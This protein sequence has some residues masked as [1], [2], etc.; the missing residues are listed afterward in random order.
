MPMSNRRKPLIAVAAALVAMASAPALAIKP[1]S[2]DY[3][4]NYKGMEATA[5]MSL[6][7]K[8]NE[9]WEYRLDLAGMGAEM[10]QST[11]FEVHDGQWRPISSTDSQRGTNGLAAM[12]VKRKAVTANYDWNQG[13]ARWT[14]DVKPDRAGPVAL[15]AGDLDG[16]LMNLVLVRDVAA[17]KPLDYRLVEDGRAK[18]QQFTVAGEETIAVAGKSHKAT[19]VV[20]KDGKREIIAWVVDGLPVPARVLQRRDGKDDIDLRLTAV[21]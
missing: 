11:V 1:F 7:S 17:G 6:A 21:K 9:R 13:V 8:G 4:A 18:R 5:T 12:L 19:R 16:M 3:A 15:Q 20:R 10:A 14:G 2:A